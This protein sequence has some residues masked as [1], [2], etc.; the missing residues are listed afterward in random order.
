MG[1]PNYCPIYN[2]TINN[3]FIVLIMDF[4]ALRYFSVLA[5]ELHFGHAAKR[6]HISQPPLSRQLGK[7]EHELGVKLLFRTKR[8]VSLT[9]A[10]QVF[11]EEV[12]G[13]LASVNEAANAA[14]RAGRG[15]IGRLTVGFFIGATYSLLPKILHRFQI[16]SPGVRLIL[17]EMELTQVPQALVSGEIDVGIL[18]PPVS[19]STIETE[20]LLREPFVAAVPENG[21][22]S[23]K[24]QLQLK[25]L[26]EEPFVMFSPGPSVLYSQ[27]M[28]ACYK[29]GFRPRIVQEARHPE[30]L[31][32]LVRSGAGI[33]L[34]ASSVQMRGS[35]GGVVFKK[36]TGPLPMTEIAIAWRHKNPSPLLLSFIKNARLA[37]KLR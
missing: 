13:I 27:I 1:G 14:R 23:S 20:V 2:L 32:G 34:V 25:E 22:F 18:R 21:K 6:L 16:Q 31:L 33:A 19:Y 17:Q 7:L 26:A 9:P 30:T 15:E 3:T 10:G 11:L 24:K 28:S 5:E 36:I 37:M 35:G 12:R 8:Q 4:K 29:A